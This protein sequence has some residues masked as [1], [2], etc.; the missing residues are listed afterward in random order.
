MA[1]Q[2]FQVSGMT[3]D[4]CVN[5]VTEEVSE[6][7]GV[8]NVQVDLEKAELKFDSESEIA[9]EVI[10]AAVKEAGYEVVV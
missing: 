7:P 5:S 9:F 3:C 2:V 1:T 6:V 4:H 10:E 8:T